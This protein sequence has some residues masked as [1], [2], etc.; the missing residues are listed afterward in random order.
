V[1][2]IA[3]GLSE[4][5]A[6]ASAGVSVRRWREYEAGRPWTNGRGADDRFAVHYDVPASWLW[7]GEGVHIGAHLS[8]RAPGKVAI[9]P[10]L[11]P[12]TRAAFEAEAPRGGGDFGGS[13]GAA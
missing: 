2:R 9:L 5:E 13:S 6:A 12:R 4:A 7:F 1:T 8:T 11:S 10:C 3:L